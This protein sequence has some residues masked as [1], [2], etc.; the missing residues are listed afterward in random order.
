MKPFGVGMGKECTR[1]L[2]AA[3]QHQGATTATGE[4]L[5]Q[6]K[7]WH[8]AGVWVSGFTCWHPWP[9]CLG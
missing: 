3:W 9:R 4:G 1:L 5:P 7:E 6:P 2:T 8:H